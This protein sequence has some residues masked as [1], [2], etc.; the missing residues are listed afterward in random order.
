MRRLLLLLAVLCPPWMSA[1][2]AGAYAWTFP[3]VA[4]ITGADAEISELRREIQRVLDAGRLAPLY[5]STSDQDSVG[6]ALYLE[7]GR[8]ITTLAWAYPYLTAEQQ[9]AV[10]AYVA[11]E[12]ADPVH[13]PWAPYPLPKNA[14][15]PRETH[16]KEKWWYEH[17]DFGARRP[18]VQTLY[19]MWLYA[20][21]SG[22]WATVRKHW[23]EIQRFFERRKDDAMLYGTMGA[24]IAMARMAER[25]D[26]PEVS[27]LEVSN[28]KAH[29]Q[30][31][32]DFADSERVA[33][34]Q[35]PAWISPYRAMYDQRMDAS[36]YRGWIFLNLC[37][38][39]ARY[40]KD[41]NLTKVSERHALGKATFPLW[42]MGQANYFTRSWTGDEGSGL[43]PEVIGMMAPVERWVLG[44]DGPTMRSYV[45]G[46]PMGIGDC[47]WLEAL[48]FAIEA[49]GTTTWV[50]VRTPAG[51]RP[52]IVDPDDQ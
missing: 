19:G 8:I 45:K 1:I 28:L 46:A 17:A 34:D 35:K 16:A 4:N 29:L 14:G 40:L 6:Y 47:Y 43:L 52:S 18:T 12:L 3:Q 36:T 11:A 27:A 50:D 26:E 25:F 30:L 7:P 49:S 21:R 41:T 42:W 37:P 39:I 5:V 44:T 38:E 13:A 9:V 51:K 33:W 10:K 20:W 24:Y 32:L 23:S 15:A 2:E 22:D 48:V 31:G